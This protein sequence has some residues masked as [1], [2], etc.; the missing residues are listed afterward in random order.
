[1]CVCVCCPS[2]HISHVSALVLISSS[3]SLRKKLIPLVG[4]PSQVTA[5]VFSAAT[6]KPQMGLA[7]SKESGPIRGF[8]ERVNNT[9][10]KASRKPQC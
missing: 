2:R 5:R 6:M 3:S 10:S 9:G 1:M 8:R 7:V 4:H